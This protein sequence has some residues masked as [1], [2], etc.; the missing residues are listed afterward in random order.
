ME[1]RV[2]EGE[3]PGFL[4]ARARRA[5]T[6]PFIVLLVAFRGETAFGRKDIQE[7]ERENE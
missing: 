1:S 5:S 3:D 7:R 2:G 6:M 4:S